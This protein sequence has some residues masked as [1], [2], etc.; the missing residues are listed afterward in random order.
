MDHKINFFPSKDKIKHIEHALKKVWLENA[1]VLTWDKKNSL[2]I[3]NWVKFSEPFKLDISWEITEI[4]TNSFFIF[5]WK[6]VQWNRFELNTDWIIWS[7]W[8]F[9]GVAKITETHKDVR[10]KNTK[11][12]LIKDWQPMDWFEFDYVRLHSPINNEFYYSGIGKKNSENEN[13]FFIYKWIKILNDE[14]VYEWSTGLKITKIEKNQIYMEER[15]PTWKKKYLVSPWTKGSL[16]YE[17]SLSNNTSMPFGWRIDAEIYMKNTDMWKKC[18]YCKT[19][20]IIDIDWTKFN[21][22]M[23]LWLI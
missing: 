19:D 13:R 22:K 20:W 15:L 1:Y 21:E 5:N 11:E 10:P 9:Y 4:T 23:A 3:I 12:I 6:V 14:R 8:E 18:Q 17:N 2:F 7:D 16:R